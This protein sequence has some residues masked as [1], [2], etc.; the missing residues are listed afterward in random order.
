MVELE[1]FDTEA[2]RP[3]CNEFVPRPPIDEVR[4]VT[5]VPFPVVRND[6]ETSDLA[7]HLPK[8]VQAYI[9]YLKGSFQI[10]I[11]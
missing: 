7:K 11:R 8:V 3:V 5:L 6:A 4:G 10:H 1:I 9:G 2:A